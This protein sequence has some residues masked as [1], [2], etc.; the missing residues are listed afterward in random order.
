MGRALVLYERKDDH[1]ITEHPQIEGREGRMRMGAGER[2]ACCV[3][4]LAKG[5]TGNPPKHDPLGGK[6]SSR[7]DP[8]PEPDP[9]RFDPFPK[10]DPVRFDPVPEPTMGQANG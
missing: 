10:P 3:I 2:I 1:D 8:M 4:G 5:E 7:S 9:V 6:S